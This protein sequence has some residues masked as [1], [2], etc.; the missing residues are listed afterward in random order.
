MRG[1]AVVGG[2]RGSWTR[3]QS[4]PTVPKATLEFSL[5]DEQDE[6]RLA[7]HAHDW[8]SVVH[9]LDQECRRRLRYESLEPELIKAL[10][11]VRETIR[12]K[13]KDLG[14]IDPS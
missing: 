8:R 10:E 9:E 12:E 7:I 13:Q 6:Y 1:V 3:A 11:W 5:P 2:R 4:K 14:L